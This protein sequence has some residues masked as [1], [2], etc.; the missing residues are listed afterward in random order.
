MLMTGDYTHYVPT[1]SPY[2]FPTVTQ[3]VEITWIPPNY[4]ITIYP[5]PSLQEKIQ[6][7][8]EMGKRCGFKI[9]VSIEEEGK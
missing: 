8:I 9:S 2:P 1:V 4:T 7:L 5:V 6:E 3:P